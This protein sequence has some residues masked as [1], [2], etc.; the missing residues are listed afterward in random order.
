MNLVFPPPPGLTGPCVWNGHTFT[1]GDG[2]SPIL[3][4]STGESGWTDD[5]TIF[6]ENTA[7]SGH[8]IDVASREHAVYSLQK[9][10]RPARPTIL[11][12]GCSSGLLL[13]I[14]RERLPDAV[15]LGADYVKGP[16]ECLSQRMP[17][18]P[19]LQ[20]DL[21]SCPL[22]SGCVD[23]VVA[24]NVLEH[25]E[26]DS[27]ALAQLHRIL[28]RGG[29]AVIE[30]PA[31][32]HLYDLYDKEL[33]HF[34]R[35]RMAEL[36]KMVRAAGF[37]IVERSHLGCFLYP[38]FAMVKKRNRHRRNVPEMTQQQIVKRNIIALKEAK[39][40]HAVMRLEQ[41]LR[42]VVYYPFGIRCLITCRKASE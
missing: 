26:D 25:I 17:R 4:Y 13:Q 39:L 35:Y 29:I 30:V 10:V 32:P 8:Y 23:A 27:A 34:R 37:D 42:P 19:L 3:A 41:W 24:L 15:L 38:A 33:L 40:M 5:L 18:I 20:F 9:H 16:L 11:E 2:T 36:S 14:L 12:V 22:P 7:G 1:V 28:K 21:T 6:H 31:G